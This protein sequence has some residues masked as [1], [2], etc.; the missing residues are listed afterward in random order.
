MQIFHK[1][2]IIFSGIFERFCLAAV[3]LHQE[4][5]LEMIGGFY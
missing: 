1:W 2:K 3:D 4:N 5:K